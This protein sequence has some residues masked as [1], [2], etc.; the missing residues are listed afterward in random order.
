MV[1]GSKELIRDINSH[2]VLTAIT[3]E[4]PIS[5]ATLS[6]K[7]GLTKATISAIVSTLMD[8]TLVEEIGSD[9][10]SKGRKPILIQ[11]NQRAGTVISIDLGVEIISLFIS[12]LK[13]ES[14]RLKQ[15]QNDYSKEE[16]IPFLIK[17]IEEAKET[18]P[19]SPY[20][21][22]GLCI[23]IHGSV[24][25][26]IVTFAPYYSYAQLDFVGKISDHF[27]LP[28]YL[29]NEANLSVIG[30]K[31]FCYNYSN[32]I[33]ISVHSGVGLGIIQDNK[34]YSGYNGNA[35]E[36]GHSIIEVE[37]RPCPCGNCGCF[38]QYVSERA[39]L[40]SYSQKRNIPLVTFEQFLTDYQKGNEDAIELTEQFIKYMAVGINN[41]LNTLNPYV[42]VI[43]SSF[44]TFIP[45]LTDRI[46][47]LLKN[48]MNIYCNLVPSRLQDASILL[49]GVC[50]CTKNFLGIEDMQLDSRLE[51]LK[52]FKGN[53]IM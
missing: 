35:G 26:N 30:E 39:L 9:Q 52:S 8:K 20:G 19:K 32:I 40:H 50:V 21:L 5:R 24:H 3:N 34:L 15:Y 31:T 33:G 10:T 22:V 1:I 47:N 41:I 36:F 27:D 42:I 17:I 12:D 2:L 48:R 16:I 49:G 29:E 6:K 7:L 25:N 51:A 4:G 14:C 18:I 38:E 23:G 44:T 13:G 28:V 43:N 46:Q 11:Q 37:G 45:R 53:D